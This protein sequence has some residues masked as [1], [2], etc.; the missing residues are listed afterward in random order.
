MSFFLFLWKRLASRSWTGQVQFRLCGC[1]CEIILLMQLPCSHPELT[2]LSPKEMVTWKNPKWLSIQKVQMMGHRLFEINFSNKCF[3]FALHENHI[4]GEL[5][6]YIS[7]CSQSQNKPA[8]NQC[9]LKVIS[10]VPGVA[11]CTAK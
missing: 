5:D 2:E 6:V 7:K 11:V 3:E 4:F 1:P 10:E 8:N 9:I